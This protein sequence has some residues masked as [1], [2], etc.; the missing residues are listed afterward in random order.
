MMLYLDESRD[1]ELTED[2]LVQGSVRSNTFDREIRPGNTEASF[3]ATILLGLLR[4][5]LDFIPH[6]P[7][8]R[9]GR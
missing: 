8:S 3:L 2:I 7:I 6:V 1:I 5:G 9:L 4:D